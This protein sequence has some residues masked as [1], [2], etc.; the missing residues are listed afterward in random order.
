MDEREW[1]DVKKNTNKKVV[2]KNVKRP[3]VYGD[4]YSY[5]KVLDLYHIKDTSAVDFARDDE[6]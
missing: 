6:R 4:N 1:G 5:E 3:V 2:K